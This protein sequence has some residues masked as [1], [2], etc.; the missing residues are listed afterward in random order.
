M[1]YCPAEPWE[2]RGCIQSRP[3]YEANYWKCDIGMPAPDAR[4]SGKVGKRDRV[5]SQYPEERREVTSE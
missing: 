2:C 4:C 1:R 3:D 5:L